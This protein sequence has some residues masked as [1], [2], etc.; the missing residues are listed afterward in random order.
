MIIYSIYKK[1]HNI[2]GLQYLGY[3]KQNPYIYK[4]SGKVWRKHIKKYGNDVTTE[5]LYQTDNIKEIKSKGIEYSEL[6]NIVESKQ[7]A[8]LKREEGDGGGNCYNH[9]ENKKNASK[10]G[11]ARAKMIK[12]TNYISP[13]KGIKTGPLQENIK[14][15]M[16]VSHK[17]MKR[18]Y[19]SDGTWF[20][21]RP[22]QHNP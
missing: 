21:I 6:W 2:T 1:T 12:E 15:K 4:G 19:R 17:G 10:G 14:A 3:T 7:W 9:T 13:L 22:H 18:S 5:I 20:W 8:N 16:S 11:I